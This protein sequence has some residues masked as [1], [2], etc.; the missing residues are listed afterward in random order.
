MWTGRG[1]NGITP[2]PCSFGAW[3]ESARAMAQFT[4]RGR[5]FRQDV[6]VVFMRVRS[7]GRLGIGKAVALAL[8]LV[9]AACDDFP[10]DARRTL[11]QVH[12]GGRPLRVG[13]SPAEPWVRAEAGADG[14]DGI[15]PDLVRAWAASEGLRIA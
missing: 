2:M 3:R 8:A 5:F 11:E 15:E 10:R 14:P 12:G 13:W 4:P 6:S 7:V 1:R 9:A